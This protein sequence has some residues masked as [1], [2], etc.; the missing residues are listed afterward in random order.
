MGFDE[1]DLF[2]ALKKFLPGREIPSGSM[3]SW[4]MTPTRWDKK[5][6]NPSPPADPTQAPQSTAHD[7]AAKPPVK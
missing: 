7:P 5:L 1:K 2:A 3:V 4:L 6:A